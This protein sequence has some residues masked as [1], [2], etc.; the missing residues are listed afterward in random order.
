MQIENAQFKLNYYLIL[1]CHVENLLYLCNSKQRLAIT[2]RILRSVMLIK[3]K[4]T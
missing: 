3:Q 4:K 1:F 2:S